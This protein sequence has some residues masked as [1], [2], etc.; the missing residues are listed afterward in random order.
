LNESYLEEGVDLRELSSAECCLRASAACAAPSRVDV[1]TPKRAAAG[2]LS[3]EYPA[4]DSILGSVIEITLFGMIGVYEFC[5]NIIGRFVS[6]MF[7]ER[8]ILIRGG[9]RSD[10][11]AGPSDSKDTGGGVE[12]VGE[13]RIYVSLTAP[14]QRC[15]FRLGS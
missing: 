2:A 7:D 12:I 9:T 13:A 15:G 6:S 8:E 14:A 1:P 5:I 4:T 3:L 10:K 11:E